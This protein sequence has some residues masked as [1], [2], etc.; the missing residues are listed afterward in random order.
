MP[1]GTPQ[2]LTSDISVL[3]LI[4]LLRL[5]L[6]PLDI[7]LVEKGVAVTLAYLEKESMDIR[8]PVSYLAVFS[9]TVK[10]LGIN[11]QLDHNRNSNHCQFMIEDLR[12]LLD[13]HYRDLFDSTELDIFLLFVD[14][15]YWPCGLAFMEKYYNDMGFD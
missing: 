12:A 3:G 2:I 6:H 4:K 9:L 11:D 5:Q 7:N 8:T 13:T 14:R 15:N 1:G 10:L